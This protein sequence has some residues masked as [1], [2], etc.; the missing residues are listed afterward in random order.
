MRPRSV[1]LVALMLAACA[2]KTA[3]PA[4]S[5][6]ALRV[7]L[8]SDAEL[9]KLGPAAD[10]LVRRPWLGPFVQ[11]LAEETADNL[12]PLRRNRIAGS[13]TT[14]D[15]LFERGLANLR[16]VGP[17]SIQDRTVQM[18][19]APVQITRFPDVHTA[20]RLLLPELWSKVAATS[21]GHLYASA[22]A[23]DIVL[24]TTSVAADDQAALRGQARIAFQSRS[25]PISP[26]ILRWTGNGW[27]LEDANPIP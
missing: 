22:P 14:A 16:Q 21:G 20:A 27:T 1:F 23:R 18:A 13:G 17:Q 11:V 5:P 2:R 10:D 24:W 12:T 4:F 8:A 6:D 19:K 25:D 15:A 7:A 9:R 3:Q 26:A